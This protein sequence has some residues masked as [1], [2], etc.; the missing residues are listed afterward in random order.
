MLSFKNVKDLS[1]KNTKDERAQLI[2]DIQ[3]AKQKW[4]DN[5]KIFG[6]ITEAELID[7]AI[8]ELKASKIRYIYLLKKLKND[9]Y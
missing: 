2:E 6:E 7:F 4:M 8:Y 3:R 9:S 1:F 5:Q